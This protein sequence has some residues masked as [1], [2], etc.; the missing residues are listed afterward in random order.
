MISPH[1]PPCPGDEVEIRWMPLADVRLTNDRLQP[2]AEVLARLDEEAAQAAR[3]AQ[4]AQQ[5]AARV[6]QP[7]ASLPR[8]WEGSGYQSSSAANPT[9]RVHLALRIDA[10]P[11]WS[12]PAEWTYWCA[13]CGHMS[14]AE[15]LFGQVTHAIPRPDKILMSFDLAPGPDD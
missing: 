3:R 13:C 14:G 12:D 10:L 9:Q 2:S 4:A 8:R 7:R 15:L 6:P 5:A 1:W 11:P